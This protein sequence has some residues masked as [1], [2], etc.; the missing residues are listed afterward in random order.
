MGQPQEYIDITDFSPGIFA[1]LH[2]F[3]GATATSNPGNV[4][5]LGPQSNGA[6]VVDDTF[7]CIVDQTGALTPLP[8][9][10][11]T[12]QAAWA[13]FATAG[14]TS[15]AHFPTGKVGYYI[16]DFRIMSYTVTDD[17]DALTERDV[18][19]VL[20]GT[21]Y[22]PDGAGNYRQLVWGVIM[23]LDMDL[24]KVVH[25]DRYGPSVV[26]SPARSIPSGCVSPLRQ[27]DG[28]RDADGFLDYGI[29]A[30]ENS[31]HF[32]ISPSRE[33]NL[34]DDNVSW[35][36]GAVPANEIALTAWS[37][38][39]GETDYPT[40]IDTS[41]AVF[42]GC[43]GIFPDPLD[44]DEYYPR[45]IGGRTSLPGYMAIAHQGRAIMASLLSRGFGQGLNSIVD[46]VAYSPVYNSALAIDITAPETTQ[47][48]ADYRSSIAG[49]D[50]IAPIGTLGS[51]MAAELLVVKHGRGGVLMRGDMDNF[52]AVN[53]PYIESTYGVVSMGINTPI[54]FV[55]GSRNGVFAWAGGQVSEKLS[56]QIDSY[57]W[58][59]DTSIVYTG[60]QG[61]FGYWHPYV[62]VPNDFLYDTEQQSWWKLE[63]SSDVA[64][65]TYGHYDVSALSGKLYAFA[66]RMVPGSDPV[67]YN[68]DPDVL[69]STYSWRS[70]PLIESRRR[71]ITVE[72]IEI[73][74]TSAY[75]WT[76][77]NTVV[78]TLTGFNEL[79]QQVSAP[80]T[81]FT[82][83]PTSN[84]YGSQVL[85]QQVLGSAGAQ[86]TFIARYIQVKIVATAASGPAPKI[87]GI[88][89]GFREAARQPVKVP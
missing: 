7:G 12:A 32:M 18:A 73:T 61:R 5:S 63:D 86:G 69:R 75:P 43:I 50:N 23:G 65:S 41:V 62:C 25:W 74:V 20:F 42:S 2:G 52:E 37:A 70:Q 6:A 84:A 67:V 34:S 79:G 80:A 54:G 51:I 58:E 47:S 14:Q 36:T 11:L 24:W 38:D 68:Y 60:N 56:K 13:G 76:A 72:D 33:G 26:P 4:S 64:R 17:H 83:N 59:H 77:A 3:S 55:Y 9:G 81:T 88:K 30:T 66:H 1:D 35:A 46:R 22:D 28:T 44:L 19:F 16:L 40:G 31:V 27:V 15:T 8:L 85:L 78:V 49:D 39:T 89:L 82:L 21:F 53:L 57:F 87:H 71:M 10:V 48:P 45:Y 29:Y